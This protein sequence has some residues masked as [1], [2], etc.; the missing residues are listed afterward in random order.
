MISS[1]GVVESALNIEAEK[2]C[3]IGQVL[4]IDNCPMIQVGIRHAFAQSGIQVETYQTI[5]KINGASEMIRRYRADLVIVELNGSSDS[6]P[7][8]LRMI[9]QLI[10]SWPK[11]R[12][13]VCTR[14]TD[15]R[16][17][18]QLVTMGVSGIYLKSEPLSALAQCVFQVMAG[19][20][21]YTFQT[22]TLATS[23]KTYPFPLTHRELDVLE[24]L[25]K[26][27]S[28]TTTAQALQR[29][30]RTVSAHKRNAMFKLELYSDSDLYSWAAQVSFASTVVN[31]GQQ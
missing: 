12:L 20:Y 8:S 4:I 7:E 1:I 23:S 25:F 27:K 13:I 24:L 19:H 21:H 18:K 29:D 15:S 3:C 22:G 10:G 5:S 11:I 31:G 2:T 30:I 16:L 17:L 28:V 6:V 26:G 9:S 14:L